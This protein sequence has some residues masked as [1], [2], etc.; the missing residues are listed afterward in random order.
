M[1][2]NDADAI[3]FKLRHNSIA[4]K[5]LAEHAQAEAGHIRA[6]LKSLRRQSTRAASAEAAQLDAVLLR[7]RDWMLP[8]LEAGSAADEGLRALALLEHFA[9]Q[10]SSGAPSELDATAL[11]RAVAA[12]RAASAPEV[13]SR[14]ELARASLTDALARLDPQE[15]LISVLSGRAWHRATL[16]YAARRIAARLE[17]LLAL[18]ANTQHDS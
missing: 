4:P 2:E 5:T 16:D 15:V 8:R 7:Y 14:I 13:L 17:R 18:D 3:S 11:D 12:L 10:I 6:H 9:A 1:R